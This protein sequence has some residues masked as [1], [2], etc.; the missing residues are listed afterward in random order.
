M[1]WW[2]WLVVG[3]TLAALE[4]AVLFSV[5]RAAATERRPGELAVLRARARNNI[6]FRR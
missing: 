5:C 6:Y 3:L 2:S 4:F 1:F